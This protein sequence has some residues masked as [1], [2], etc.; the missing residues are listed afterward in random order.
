M[1]KVK[2]GGLKKFLE[3]FPEYFVIGVNHPFNPHVY[4]REMVDEDDLLTIG[5]S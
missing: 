5:N 4:L 1:S 2:F 3:K